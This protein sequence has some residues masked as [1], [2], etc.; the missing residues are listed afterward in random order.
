MIQL[1][2]PACY[3]I[4]RIKE[5]SSMKKY[6][7]ILQAIL[8]TIIG[9][10]MLLLYMNLLNGQGAL[11][12]LGII[13]VIVAAYY[14]VSGITGAL[15]SK[16]K[17]NL[18]G[19]LKKG[20]V[21]IFP[22]FMFVVFLITVINGANALGP[23]GWVIAILSLIAALGFAIAAIFNWVANSEAISKLTTLLGILFIL[24][25]ALTVFFDPTGAPN[26]L[27]NIELA[28]TVVYVLY[29]ILAVTVLGE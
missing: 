22:I 11:L 8:P 12:A 19:L 13:G 14:L 18:G 6:G 21:V 25:L 23:T 16:N 10:F 29:T 4:W 7:S 15:L 17:G 26:A 24:A 9:A 5:V 20:N 2:A 3:D 28:S 1:R 27:G